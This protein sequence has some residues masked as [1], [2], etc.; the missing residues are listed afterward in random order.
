[1]DEP[2]PPNELA[3]E[4]LKKR[5]DRERR[6][7]IESETIAENALRELYVRQRQVD[8]L[9]VIAA[10]CNETSSVDVAI[11][12][13]IEQICG[14]LGWPVGHAW[15]AD[16]TTRELRATNLWHLREPARFEEFRAQTMSSAAAGAGGIVDRVGKTGEAKWTSD[17]GP[18]SGFARSETA[19]KASL[20]VAFAF[21]VLLTG[22][23]VAVLE[24]FSDTQAAPEP[25]V[26]PL[27]AYVATLLGRVVERRRAEMAA[28]EML[29]Q[30]E[31]L[32]SMGSMLAGVAH[33]LNNPLSVVMGEAA[34]LK[35]ELRDDRSG[36]R[37]EKI[38]QAS[39]RCA[40]I[41]RSFLALARQR[42]PERTTIQINETVRGAIEILAYQLRLD[43][44]ALDW[45]LGDDLAPLWGDP[46]ELQQLILNLVSN[47]HHSMRRST[48]PRRLTV[49]TR[50][51]RARERIL[52]EIRDTGP[53][54]PEAVLGRIFDPFF[55]TKEP[56]QGTGLGLSLCK[57]IVHEHGGS[58]RAEN[59]A[60]GA[61]F[62]VDLPSSA[63][64]ESD[65]PA[66]ASE[67][68]GPRVVRGRS[69]LVVEDEPDVAEVLKDMLALDDHRVDIAANGQLALELLDDHEYDLIL[70]DLR[71]P[72]LDGPGLYRELE[73]RRP[74]LCRR[75]IFISG[76]AL[77]REVES[78]MHEVD[79][80]I[81]S[82]PIALKT[83]R[84]AV[85]HR[86]RKL[87]AMPRA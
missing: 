38:T 60:G 42:P 80:T 62:I 15:L 73:R 34:L 10:A 17:L 8:L 68:P 26:L 4:L 77:N 58:I 57:G 53:G 76:D 25:G 63:G 84:E 18:E 65:A 19:R 27:M 79:A 5:L 6:A 13:A 43:E 70:S 9:Q 39:E 75:L 11:E 24:F 12:I 37:V 71:M 51:D 61:A 1:M 31:K 29:H 83:F 46:H 54:I 86:L 41:V 44:V 32:A 69:I 33:E 14:H 52:V 72:Q 74:E 50:G 23:V 48:G 21:P 66:P 55:T 3:F 64:P 2:A 78:F 59:A 22:D 28:Q 30:T 47:A 45:Q 82:K 35:Q 87:T 49:V 7:R 56:G 16:P 36:H 81:L 85:Q 20:R 67:R 40:R